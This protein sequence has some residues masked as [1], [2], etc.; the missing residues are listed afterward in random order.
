MHEIRATLPPEHVEK[1]T[2]LAREAGIDRIAVSDVYV[3]GPD[4]TAAGRQRGNLHAEGARFCGGVS[5][6]R[7][8]L[9]AP[10]IR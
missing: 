3:H 8:D 7:R 5:G 1:A 9:A 10:I 6:F 4:A 2:R